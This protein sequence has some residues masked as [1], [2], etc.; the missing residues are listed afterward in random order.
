MNR[1]PAV[2]LLILTGALAFSGCSPATTGE[3]STSEASPAAVPAADQIKT[4]D[5]GIAWAQALDESVPATELSNGIQKIG[6]L[7][8][9]QDIWFE[10]NNTI[11]A[12]LISLNAEVLADPDEASSKVDDLQD[13]IDDL[14]I[15]IDK[16]NA[17]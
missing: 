6:E 2:A 4:I 15:A 3:S 11:G 7:V 17:P 12:D 8:P 1:T 10:A 9:E 13:I 14:E 16:G 5:D